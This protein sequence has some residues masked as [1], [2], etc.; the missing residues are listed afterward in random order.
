MELE[1][2]L[3]ETLKQILAGIKDAQGAAKA[4]GGLINPAMI[5]IHPGPVEGFIR[6][7]AGNVAQIIN[8]D[9]ALT[10]SE[11]TATKGGIGV[12]AGVFNLGSA[13]SSQDSNTTVSR[14]RFS[15]PIILPTQT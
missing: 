3:S 6:D 2:F 8:F 10:A 11:G 5:P 15:V 12:V 4:S 14:V 7:G 13:G 9:I 1:Q